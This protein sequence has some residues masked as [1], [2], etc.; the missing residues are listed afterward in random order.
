MPT[1]IK[2][3]KC[4]FE[5]PI[6]DAVSEEYKKELREQMV[7]FKKQKEEELYKKEQEW[8]QQLQQQERELLLKNENDKKQLQKELEENLRK[9]S[10]EIMKINW[11]FYNKTMPKQKKN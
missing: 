5:F 11:H 10:S 7:N 4:S 3:P 6:E 2:C 9:R 1:N 8:K